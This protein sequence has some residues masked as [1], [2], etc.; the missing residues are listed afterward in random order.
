MLQFLSRMILLLLFT[1]ALS[2][3]LG[4]ENDT[5]VDAAS[6]STSSSPSPS[7]SPS[8]SCRLYFAPSTIKG[9]GRG[10]YSIEDIPKHTI[11]QDA[12]SIPLYTGESLLLF[13]VGALVP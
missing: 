5:A 3:S 6:A 12:P 7:P 2:S 10:M 8:P 9:A 1:G 13:W 4:N 11:M